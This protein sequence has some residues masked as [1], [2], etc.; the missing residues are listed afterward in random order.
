MSYTDNLGLYRPNREDEVEVD[1]SL[2]NNF[3]VIDTEIKLMKDDVTEATTKVTA[4]DSKTTTLEITV[5]NAAVSLSDVHVRL[6]DVEYDVSVLK[7]GGGTGGSAFGFI[8]GGNFL[9]TYTSEGNKLDG[10]GF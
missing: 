6:N 7:E 1:V 9:D 10:G 8:D 3:D 5:N 2:T 4:L